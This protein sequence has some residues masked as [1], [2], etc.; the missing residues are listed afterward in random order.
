MFGFNK[1]SPMIDGP[2]EF[3]ADVEI[4]RPA[5]EVFP[6]IDLASPRFKDAQMGAKVS[7]VENSADVYALRLDEM[8]DVVFRLTVMERVE[9]ERHAFEAV[10]EPKINALVKS[11][12]THVIEPLGEKACRVTLTTAATFDEDLSDEEI[13]SEIAIM[14]Q[15]VMGDMDKLKTLAEDG[16]DAA[17]ALQPAEM[18][19]DIEFDLGDLDIDW[20]DIEPQQ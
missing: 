17:M 5:A 7:P 18:E 10:I 2:V 8:D 4:D 12:E 6:L 3:T 16:V 11:V 15:A 20:N 14:N 19:F 9:N 1:K 13:T